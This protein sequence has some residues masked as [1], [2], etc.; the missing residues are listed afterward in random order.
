MVSKSLPSIVLL[1]G[2][3]VRL[4]G[5]FLGGSSYGGS[6]ETFTMKFLEEES[7]SHLLMI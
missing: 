3:T 2:A 1:Q 7:V 4:G 6:W 5:G